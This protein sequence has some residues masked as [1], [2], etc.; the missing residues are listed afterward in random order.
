MKNGT[1]EATHADL[2]KKTIA[3]IDSIARQ[4]RTNIDNGSPP[5][6]KLP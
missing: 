5:D 4:V 1:P 2:D 3:L 6:I